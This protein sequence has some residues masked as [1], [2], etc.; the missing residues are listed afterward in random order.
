[1]SRMSRVTIQVD[2][3][4]ETKELLIMLEQTTTELESKHKLAETR[5]VGNS[6]LQQSAEPRSFLERKT[7]LR[8]ALPL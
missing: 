7:D 1:M 6:G 3:P 4:T 2:T 5:K 8:V